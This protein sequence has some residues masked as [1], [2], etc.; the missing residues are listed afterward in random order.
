MAKIFKIEGYLI[1]PNGDYNKEDIE[2]DLD[3]N[4][5]AIAHHIKV[6]ERDIGEWEDDNPLN[7]YNCPESECEKYFS[8]RVG[9]DL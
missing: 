4:F 1:D 7:Y 6:Q 2:V 9:N 8:R 5:D 3:Q